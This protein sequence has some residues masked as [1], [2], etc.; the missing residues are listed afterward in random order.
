ML[1][2]A[3]LLVAIE[4][5]SAAVAAEPKELTNAQQ[6][7]EALQHPTEVDR[8]RYITRLVR[9]RE[10]FTRRDAEM[11]FAIDK[12]VIRHPTP[13]PADPHELAKRVIGK[14]TSPR[15]QYLY[16][17]DDTWT[18]LPESVDGEKATYGIWRIQGNQFSQGK[19]EA[20]ASHETIILLNSTDFVW[21][22]RVAPYYM[23]RGDVFPWRD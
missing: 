22:T 1:R 14:W 10:S 3:T 20:D 16:R 2:V 9:L 4:I 23:R 15:H 6:E 13:V 12:E 7:F 11:M 17:A 18:M 8:V 21:S 5:V 19:S